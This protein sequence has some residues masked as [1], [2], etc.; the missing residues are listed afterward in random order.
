MFGQGWEQEFYPSGC[1]ALDPPQRA[2]VLH[3]L[4]GVLHAST[5]DE[6]AAVRGHGHRANTEVLRYGL[7]ALSIRDLSQHVHLS[8]GRPVCNSVRGI[9]G[10]LEIEELEAVRLPADRIVALDG[11]DI[12]AEAEG[13]EDLATGTVQLKYGGLVEDLDVLAIGFP[14][15]VVH[16]EAE[17]VQVGGVADLVHRLQCALVEPG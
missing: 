5:L 8:I 4:G 1:H 6:I 11:C 2:G 12:L 13:A 15:A 17:V 3:Q 9:L 14:H 10:W 7:A 16:R